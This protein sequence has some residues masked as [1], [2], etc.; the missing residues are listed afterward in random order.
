MTIFCVL[1]FAVNCSQQTKTK[2]SLGE[3]N[4]VEGSSS[5]ERASLEKMVFRVATEG[6]ESKL[7]ELSLDC[8]G[9]EGVSEL[10][11]NRADLIK[12]V[13]FASLGDYDFQF[14][15]T[16]KGK[17]SFNKKLLSAFSEYVE[18]NLIEQ[19][20]VTQVRPL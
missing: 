9:R 3:S 18:A 8:L 6:S 2:S 11:Q 14:L 15:K 7:V 12:K 1:S 20:V 4:S 5:Q 16:Q 17:D 19:V 10:V 13:I